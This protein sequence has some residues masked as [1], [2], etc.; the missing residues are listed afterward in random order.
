MANRIAG[1]KQYREDVRAHAV[2]FG[3]NPDGIPGYPF[4]G[5]TNGEAK[6]KYQR[7]LAS[8]S[9]I[10]VA[11]AAV[12]QITDIDFSRVSLDQPLPRIA[13]NGEQGSLDKF[14]QW[15]TNKTLR[16]DGRDRWRWFSDQ[17]P[18]S[19]DQLPLINEVCEGLVSELQRS[20]LVRRPKRARLCGKLR[21]NSEQDAQTRVRLRGV[22]GALFPKPFPRA[23]ISHTSVPERSF[24]NA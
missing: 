22:F 3:R 14:A 21:A 10:H 24:L 18:V 15:G 8:D 4:L 20:G 9:F 5:E 19:A 16:Q 13:T 7:L 2:K 1:M 6:A 11:L 23:M 17:H 12:G